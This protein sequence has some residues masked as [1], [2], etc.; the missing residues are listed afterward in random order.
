MSDRV[1][2]RHLLEEARGSRLDAA[3]RIG[4]G[5]TTMYRWIKAG[6]LDQ[7]IDAIQARYGPPHAGPPSWIRSSRS[8]R[9][10]SLSFRG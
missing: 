4:V 8:F 1:L 6:L 7:P 5:R 3:R 10:A 9:R 2:L